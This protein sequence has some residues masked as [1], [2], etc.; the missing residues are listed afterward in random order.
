MYMYITYRLELYSWDLENTCMG[1]KKK[2]APKHP[3]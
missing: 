1:K 3:L 2:K